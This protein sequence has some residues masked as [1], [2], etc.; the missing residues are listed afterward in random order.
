ML[1]SSYDMSGFEGQ[2]MDQ[3]LHVQK[4]VCILD[5]HYTYGT[6][7]PKWQWNHKL[8]FLDI[9]EEKQKRNSSFG[10]QVNL[11]D[12]YATKDPGNKCSYK[13]NRMKSE[14]H[15]LNG[16][17]YKIFS[18]F[19]PIWTYILKHLFSMDKI[20]IFSCILLN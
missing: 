2:Y 10:E 5:W 9:M 6:P 3:T 14:H 12:H 19:Q 4:Y 15:T 7:Q 1:G 11:D 13:D 20:I 18:G 16:S 8:C 17:S